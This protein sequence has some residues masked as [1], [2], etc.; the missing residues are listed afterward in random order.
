MPGLID[1][2][3]PSYT[4][5][6]AILTALFYLIALAGLLRHLYLNRVGNSFLHAATT[7]GATFALFIGYNVALQKLFIINSDV[8]PK[9]VSLTASALGL[10]VFGIFYAIRKSVWTG[11]L[12]L[13]LTAALALGLFALFAV[14]YSG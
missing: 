5:V 9:E 14:T 7:V 10:L 1:V 8:R 6:V 12:V 3:N 11:I 13:F 2:S 4:A